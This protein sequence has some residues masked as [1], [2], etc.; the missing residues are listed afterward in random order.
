MKPRYYVDTCK[1]GCGWYKVRDQKTGILKEM[2]TNNGSMP[3][4]PNIE[5]A[6]R[7]AKKLS[8]S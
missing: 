1:C 3:A 8:T 7:F 2:P 5:V 6:M 4:T